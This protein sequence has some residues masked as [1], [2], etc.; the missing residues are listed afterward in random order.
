[1]TEEQLPPEPGTGE[2]DVPGYKTED[3][4]EVLGHE[5][6][7]ENDQELGDNEPDEDEGDD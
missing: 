4:P 5:E 3:V 7:P 1:M 2:D 6:P